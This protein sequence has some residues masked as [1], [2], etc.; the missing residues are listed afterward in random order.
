MGTITNELPT[1]PERG[2]ADVG[3][4][5]AA[6]LRRRYPAHAA[7]RVARDLGVTVRTAEG[8]LAGQA[9]PARV[10]VR[11]AALHG[12]ALALEVL[13]PDSRAA[14]D[15]RLSAELDAVGDRLARLAADIAQL[16]G[17]GR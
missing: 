5:W 12:A 15:A 16:R 10:L 9:P 11:A 1:D 6:A 14:A 4:R 13:V 17:D 3:A 8:Y 7:K 2:E